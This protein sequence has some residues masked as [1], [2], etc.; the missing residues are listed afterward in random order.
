[1]RTSLQMRGVKVFSGKDVNTLEASEYDVEALAS[2]LRIEPSDL[3]LL[4]A[5]TGND[6][7]RYFPTR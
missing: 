5:L 2:Y 4:A 1:M 3:P 7:G 6:M